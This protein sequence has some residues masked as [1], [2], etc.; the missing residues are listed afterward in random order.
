MRIQILILGFKGLKTQAEYSS[1]L[2]LNGVKISD[3]DQLILA[4][5]FRVVI[6]LV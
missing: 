3:I 4:L 1:A 6:I 5:I 2:F